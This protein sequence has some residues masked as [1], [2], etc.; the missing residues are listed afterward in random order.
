MIIPFHKPIIPKSFDRLFNKS[1]KNG[2]L[3]TG[4]NVNEFEK[5]L[6]KYTNADYVVAVNSCT[7]ALHLVLA[8]QNFK[9]GDKFLVPT[10]TFV[11]S[12]EVG[13]Y[14]GMEPVLIDSEPNGFNMDL[15]KIEDILK[16]DKK[17]K[18]II[19]VHFAGESINLDIIFELA[20]KYNIFVL[21]DSAH[22]LELKYQKYSYN[23]K[24]RAVALSF[25]ANKN[26]TTAGEGG[27]VLTNN[28][29]LANT[30]RKLSLHGMSKD[31]WDRFKFGSKWSYDV[32]MLGYKYNMTDVSASFGISQLKQVEEWKKKRKNIVRFYNENFKN[33]DGV[34][35]PKILTNNHAW[36]LYIITINENYWKI[37]R[38][39]IIKKLNENG[40]G[41]SM[42]YIP[43][44]MH[45]YYIKKYSLKNSDYP[46]SSYLS[47]SIISLPL[48]PALK[49]NELKYIVNTFLNV[50]KNY[51]VE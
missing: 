34:I 25:Y 5:A 21:E 30:V 17:I 45:S 31:G 23:K 32:S 2:W 12:A 27:A 9:K 48:Y 51:K 14:L 13:E 43:I 33:I 7:A 20:Y 10:H 1:I 11:A 36:H 37:S 16:K 8:S 44:H 4:P 26:I 41:T 6:S 22:A 50:W 19:P 38:N 46:R 24:H 15:N 39:K 47:Q 40:I 28:S 18:A 49:K 3:T 42:H 35:T 29:E